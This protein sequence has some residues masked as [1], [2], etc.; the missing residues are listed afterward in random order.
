MPIL[1][2]A[3]AVL[4][5]SP[6]NLV[7]FLVTLFALQQAFVSAL[8]AVR[9]APGRVLARRWMWAAGG[10]LA[11]RVVLIIVGLLG[12][13]GLLAPADVLPSLERWVLVLTA[14]VLAWAAL[15]S[16]TPRPWHTPV[17]L[18]LLGVTALAYG[19]GILL[20]YG[21]EGGAE[22]LRGPVLWE[23]IGVLLAFTLT[24]ILTLI[25]RP[26]AWEWVLG[27]ALFW[28]LGTVAQLMWGDPLVPMD[29]WQRLASLVALPLLSVLVHHQLLE[30]EGHLAPQVSLS[31]QVPLAEIV[32]RVGSARD[33]DSALILASS[34]LA[35]LLG[36]EISAVA[37]RSKEEEEDAVQVVAIHPPTAAQMEPPRL[38]LADYDG[39]RVA[40]EEG[41][42]AVATQSSDEPWMAS[43]YQAL[44]FEEPRPLAVL[45][46]RRQGR[47]LGVLMLGGPPGGRRWRETDLQTAHQVSELLAEAIASARAKGVGVGVRSAE[48]RAPD[49]DRD[50]LVKALGQAK[51][52]IDAL[53]ARI[54]ALVQEIKARDEEILALNTEAKSRSPKASE[55]ELTVWQNEVRQLADEQEAAQ[56]KIEELTAD[57]NLLLDERAR[58]TEELLEVR[59]TLERIESHRDS[60]E[61]EVANLRS[62]LQ[63]GAEAVRVGAA[64]LLSSN[65]AAAAGSQPPEGPQGVVG[66]VIADEDG[67]ITMADALARRMLRLPVGDAVGM[68]I[69]GAY[70]DSRWSQ[71]IDDLLS[72]TNGNGPRRA[73]LSLPVDDSTIEAD[74]A[75]LLGRDGDVHGLVVTLH[76]AD[77]DIER[78]E[79]IAGLANEFRTPMT[80]ITGYS[81]LLLGEQA[82]ILTEMQQQFLERLKANVEQLN[83]LLND[84]VQV[85]SLDSRAIELSPQP[86]NLIEIIEEAVMGLSARFQERKLAVQLD[87][88]SELSS[89]EA[90]RDSLYQ[91]MLR[92]LSNAVLCSEEGTQVIISAREEE[93]EGTR[94]LRISVEDTG[95]GIAPEDYPRV[96]RRFYRADQPLVEGMGE[97]GVGMAMAKTLVEAS[98]GRIWVESEPGVGSTFS[99]LLPVDR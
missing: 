34:R 21:A 1:D 37:L 42:T 32:Q 28:L 87:L 17:L 94:H 43:L 47:S 97:T 79:A 52:Q 89:V 65:E 58:L 29:G 90:D 39:L 38:R 76:S 24:A 12:V 91:I 53:N 61:E 86:V 14:L 30:R 95:G 85:A 66:L 13:M 15:L 20:R 82:G 64:P 40:F 10:L 81:D 45:P 50:R 2:E 92:L 80:A 59:H 73:H 8:T 98:G 54:K 49:E 55:S 3:V 6:G 36:V 51:K 63:A 46:L 19:A 22:L 25:S 93:A 41:Q 18:G 33:L 48:A 16:S 75:T 67:Q 74:L 99:F 57:R 44:G 78:Y 62:Q 96:F 72:E 88:P 70:P 27:I 4:T 31:D 60:L 26:E 35:E 56:R 68:P 7:Y 9:A 23:Q 11:A 84:L 83:H 71:T 77:S 69:N 5:E